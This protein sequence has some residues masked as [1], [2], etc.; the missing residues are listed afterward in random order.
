MPRRLDAS[1]WGVRWGILLGA[2]GIS[3]VLYDDNYKAP[4]ARNSA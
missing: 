3:G 4:V 1:E 2:L